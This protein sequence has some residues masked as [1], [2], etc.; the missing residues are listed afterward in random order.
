MLLSELRQ[1]GSIGPVTQQELQ[2][3][4]RSSEEGGQHGGQGGDHQG[5]SPRPQQG[6]PSHHGAAEQEPW[7]EGPPD[8]MNTRRRSTGREEQTGASRGPA[9]RPRKQVLVVRI[10]TEEHQRDKFRREASIDAWTRKELA[11]FPVILRDC[12]KFFGGSPAS[13]ERDL[14]AVEELEAKERRAESRKMVIMGG[15][16]GVGAGE[17]A[18]VVG[19]SPRAGS[20]SGEAIEVGAGRVLLESGPAGGSRRR[21]ADTKNG[22][23][24]REGHDF[25]AGVSS[26]EDAEALRKSNNLKTL[27]ERQRRMLKKWKRE[28]KALSV[29]SFLLDTMTSTSAADFSLLKGTPSSGG[30]SSLSNH[31]PKS[32]ALV[33]PTT[34]PQPL[35]KSGHCDQPLASPSS[36]KSWSSTP[37]SSGKTPRSAPTTSSHYHH[38]TTSHSHPGAPRAGDQHDRVE[39]EKR[40]HVEPGNHDVDV[41]PALSSD[42]SSDRSDFEFAGITTQTRSTAHLDSLVHLFEGA[43]L[44]SQDALLRS[45]ARNLGY[46]DTFY[47]ERIRDLW[48]KIDIEE[49]GF[50]GYDEFRQIM[51]GLIVGQHIVKLEQRRKINNT[52]EGNTISTGGGSGA[53][54]ADVLGGSGA[55]VEAGAAPASG[56][57]RSWAGPRLEGGVLE[58]TRTTSKINGEEEDETKHLI[59][60]ARLKSMWSQLDCRCAGIIDFS[61]FVLW[62]LKNSEDSVTSQEFLPL[63]TPPASREAGI[64]SNLARW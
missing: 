45:I 20:S 54:T 32:Q 5:P 55:T 16:V 22:G 63:F 38:G 36:Q 4:S 23:A 49:K 6:G 9:R 1:K 51:R 48:R 13:A 44:S 24:T 26:T 42:H 27:D 35:T 30:G 37:N 11:G 50:I 62:W 39:H 15:K 10:S 31:S 47:L 25:V 34:T 18:V 21:L 28:H 61:E 53:R 17:K 40:S 59:P 8:E 14:L 33:P 57:S 2:Q 46:Q 19:G 7:S 58:G 60:E 29:P 43:P 64:N 56:E 12:S 41:T 52:A 3:S